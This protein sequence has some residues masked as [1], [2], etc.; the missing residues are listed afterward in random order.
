[1]YQIHLKYKKLSKKITVTNTSS[2]HHLA[3]LLL[4][5]F[6]IKEIKEKVIGITDQSGKFFDLKK[7]A[8]NISDFQKETY[9]LVTTKDLNEDN[10][11]FGNYHLI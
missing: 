10:M 5:S 4:L 8:K 3:N 6:G 7:I 2:S 9:Y 1:M 11:S